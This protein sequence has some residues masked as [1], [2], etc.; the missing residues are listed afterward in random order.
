MSNTL[1][2]GIAGL[3]TV[4]SEVARLI[5]VEAP[6]HERRS[7]KKLVVTAVSA[8][9]KKKKRSADFSSVPWAD[10]PADLAARPDVDAVVELMGGAEGAAKQLAEATLKASKPLITANKALLAHHGQALSELARKQNA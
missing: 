1:R 2:L 9:D 10:N 5:Q 8:R 3:G 6:L 4:G 7:G